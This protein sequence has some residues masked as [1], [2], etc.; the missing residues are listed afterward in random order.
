MTRLAVVDASPLIY[1][2]RADLFY[3][4]RL[5]GPEI[6]VPEAVSREI[7]ARGM[8]DETASAIR[9]ASWLREVR[10][11]EIPSVIQAWNLGLGE[12]T[13]LAWALANP[14]CRA[15]IDDLQGRRC[16][17][18]LG[19]PLRGTLG[20]VLLAKRVGQIDRARPIVD[21]LRGAGMYL[22]PT[23]ADAALSLVGE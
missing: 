3:L 16:A 17:E 10:I 15:I 8:D 20:L 6:I 19:V 14:G 9:G 7:Q 18:A 5:A 22:S 12:S 1:L 23:V 4:L 21:R 13:V 2:A 11:R